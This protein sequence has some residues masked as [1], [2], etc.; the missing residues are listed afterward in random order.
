MKTTAPRSIRSRANL[1]IAL[2]VG[3][4]LFLSGC[5][6]TYSHSPAQ[7]ANLPQEVRVGDRVEC[8][9]QD[10]TQKS[11]TVTA[12]EPTALVGESVRLPIADISSLEVTRFDGVKTVKSV[13]K[14]VGGAVV[15]SALVALCIVT[16]GAPL[17]SIK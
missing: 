11:F 12:V 1:A 7:G 14:V 6:S 9:L 17:W 5:M 15:I 16:R 10:G 3:L 8:K 13:G 4:S 2:T